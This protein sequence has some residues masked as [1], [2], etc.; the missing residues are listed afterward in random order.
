MKGFQTCFLFTLV[1]IHKI[2]YLEC[3]ESDNDD[4]EGYIEEDLTTY[5]LS[6]DIYYKTI[7]KPR[8]CTGPLDDD[9]DVTMNMEYHGDQD[10]VNV[11]IE[12]AVSIK[13][14]RGQTISLNG[15]GLVGM[16]LGEK[17][18]LIIPKEK[19]RELK[20]LLPDISE[21]STYLEV[22]LVILNGQKWEKFDSG[23]VLA[24]LEEIDDE[25][26]ERVVTDGDTLAVEYEGS[27][28]NGTVFDSSAARGAPF[29]PFVQGRR[30]II[31]GY[32]IALEGRCLGE[33][34]KMVVPPHLA[35]GDSG[36]E[37]AI[38]GGAT[39]NFDVRLV[40][41]ND[42]VWDPTKEKK[43]LRWETAKTMEDCVAM[44]GKDDVLFIHYLA[45]REDGSQFGS[46]KES[47]P[48]PYG[49]FRLYTSGL[50][51]VPGLNQA[52]EGMCLGESRKVF[53][54]PRIGWAGQYET[55]EVMVDLVKVNNESADTAMPPVGPPK[56]EL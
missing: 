35:Y 7:W 41:L 47:E 29:G 37:G 1:L 12:K 28:E 54:P 36:V 51:N 18:S 45:T 16:C 43:A 14:N 25:S 21:M 24:L 2:Q 50:S 32:E 4:E 26:C 44:A 27:L 22:E 55:M 17:R 40:K 13:M 9:D 39:L 33:R 3:L 31:A 38:P 20:D 52:I 48:E 46:V 34:F 10:G 6:G 42:A 49:P 30:Q 15:H 19:I 56:T 5:T 11:N 23:L 8:D 53:L